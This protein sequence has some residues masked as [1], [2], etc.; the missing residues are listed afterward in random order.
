MQPPEQGPPTPPP[1]KRRAGSVGD[2][3]GDTKSRVSS[4]WERGRGAPQSPKYLLYVPDKV[5]SILMSDTERPHQSGREQGQSRRSKAFP[6]AHPWALEREGRTNQR[7][8]APRGSLGRGR[9][10]DGVCAESETKELMWAE[11]SHREEA[12]C[13]RTSRRGN[14]EKVW[15]KEVPNKLLIIV[16]FFLSHITY[17]GS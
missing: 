4:T 10:R 15:L 3:T 17:T 11:L 8:R 16:F 5:P 9:Q 13:P 2:R 14:P 1:V 12:E 7:T 6:S